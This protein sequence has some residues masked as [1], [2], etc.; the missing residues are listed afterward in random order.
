MVLPFLLR[1][2]QWLRRPWCRRWLWAI[3]TLMLLTW[4]VAQAA[5]PGTLATVDYAKSGHTLE[6]LTE[7][8]P[9]LPVMDIRLAGIEAPDRQQKPWGP[10]ARTCLADQMPSRVR[11]EPQ[12]STPDQY[13]RLWAYVWAD[14][15]LVN[16]AVLQA[17]C[18]FLDSDRLAQ[19][20]YGE[21]LIY[22]QE[23]ARLLGRGI[24]SPVRPLRETPS[25]FHQRQ[26]NS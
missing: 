16:A 21:Q 1:Y 9:D 10:D 24:W 5:P 7:L 2:G 6:L 26:A 25:A 23:A 11:I 13:N 12:N 22:A 8:S 20:R 19:Q 4:G 3:A 17:G 18:A 15:V 14:Q